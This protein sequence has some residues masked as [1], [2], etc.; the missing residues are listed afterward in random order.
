MDEEAEATVAEGMCLKK[1][2]SIG[3]FCF[4]ESMRQSLTYQI[5]FTFSP[6]LLS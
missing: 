1:G 4:E 6:N 5:T 2:F 3:S